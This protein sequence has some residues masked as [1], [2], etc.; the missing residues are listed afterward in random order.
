MSVFLS[1]PE[2]NS[3]SFS[4]S[5]PGAEGEQ[6]RGI[7]LT[8]H[9]LPPPTLLSYQPSPLS[10]PIFKK[11]KRKKKEK[12]GKKQRKKKRTGRWNRQP[13]HETGAGWM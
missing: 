4:L 9:T 1:Q 7:P 12:K 3:P 11:K 5:F 6:H 8:K 10:V 2:K 13:A